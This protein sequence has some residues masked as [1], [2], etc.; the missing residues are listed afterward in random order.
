[1]LFPTSSGAALKHFPDLSCELLGFLP[2]TLQSPST[3]EVR[4]TNQTELTIPS[5]EGYLSIL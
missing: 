4:V 2:Q 5:L 1:M 3:V